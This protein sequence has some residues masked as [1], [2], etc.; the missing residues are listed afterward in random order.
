MTEIINGKEGIIQNSIGWTIR[1]VRDKIE[2]GFFDRQL[3][4]NKQKNI[5]WRGLLFSML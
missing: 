5:I 4:I 2:V 1:I 3:A